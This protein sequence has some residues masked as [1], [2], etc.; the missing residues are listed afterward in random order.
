MITGLK[1]FQISKICNNMFN[2]PIFMAKNQ[3]NPLGRK[4]SINRW[5][6]HYYKW[7]LYNFVNWWTNTIKPLWG[8]KILPEMSNDSKTIH[9][10]LSKCKTCFKTFSW[11]NIKLTPHPTIN[12]CTIVSCQRCHSLWYICTQHNNRFSYTN[13]SKMIQYFN[14]LHPSSQLKT[15]V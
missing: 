4:I 15:L 6:C 11:I 14:N 13:W 10:K 1:E 9:P 8:I 5:K 2:L 12:Q 3:L 7:V